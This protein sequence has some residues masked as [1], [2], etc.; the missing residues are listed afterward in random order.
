MTVQLLLQRGKC[1]FCPGKS[2]PCDWNE[3]KI[4][5]LMPFGAFMPS[6]NGMPSVQFAEKIFRPFFAIWSR[7]LNFRDGTHPPLNT[8]KQHCSSIS[9]MQCL[10]AYAVQTFEKLILFLFLFWYLFVSNYFSFLR[11]FIHY[12]VVANDLYFYSKCTILSDKFNWH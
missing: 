9:L 2:V 5:S 8:I 10:F 6:L 3:K 1:G 11:R 12:S 7:K 4:E